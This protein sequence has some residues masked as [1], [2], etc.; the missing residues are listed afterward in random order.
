M[1]YTSKTLKTWFK[2]AG[3]R[4]IKTV[5]QAALGAFASSAVIYEVDW[6]LVLG[7]AAIAGIT[8]LLTSVA[9]VPELPDAD[10]DG[11]PDEVDDQN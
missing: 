1:K 8:S 7:T 2:A 9:G 6:R 5:A 3:I 4:A 10:G 11:I